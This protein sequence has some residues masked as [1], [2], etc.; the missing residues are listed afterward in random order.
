[1]NTDIDDFAYRKTPWVQ[2]PSRKKRENDLPGYYHCQR[3]KGHKGR[4]QD[5]HNRY[6]KDPRVLG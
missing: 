3:T 6:W 1:M 5:V 2:C 4:H